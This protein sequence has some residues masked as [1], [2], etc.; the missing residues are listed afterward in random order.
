MCGISGIVNFDG[1][2]V[3]RSILLRMTDALAHRGPD[4]SGLWIKR[5]VGFGHRRLAIRDLSD[6]GRQPMHDASESV[7]VTYNGEIYNDATIRSAIAKVAPVAFHSTCDAEVIAPAYAAWQT[8]AFSMMEGMFAI[9]LWDA[10]RQ[11]V[12]LAR[13]PS[14]IKPLYYSW[15]G[16]SFRFASEIKGLLADPVHHRNLSAVNLHRYLAQGYPGPTHTLVE[17]IHAVPPGSFLVASSTGIRVERYWKPTRSGEIDDIDTALI[18]FDR[19]W[20]QV[21]EDMLIS[22]VPV[23]LLLSGGIDSSL[24]ASTL[25]DRNIPAFT[26][27]FQQ[28]VFDETDVARGIAGHFGLQSHP[29]DVDSFAEVEQRFR[30]VVHGYDGNYADSS[31]LAFHAVCEGARAHV[32]VVLTGDG[33]DEF[34]GGYDTY[35]ASRVARYL[36]AIIPRRL[37]EEVSLA[38]FWLDRKGEMKVSVSE[39]VA[40]LAAGIAHANGFEHAQWRRYTYPPTAHALYSADMRA[41]VD[42]IDPLGEYASESDGFSGSTVDRCLLA[43]QTYY[44]P[45]DL[46]VKSD[47]MSMAHSI[48]VR[49]PFLDRRMMEFAGTLHSNLLTPLFGPDK[50]ILRMALGRTGVNEQVARA[51]KRGF[52]VPVAYHL[53]NGLRPLGERLLD[54]NADVLGA[55]LRPEVVSSLWRAHQNRTA[56]HGYVLWALLTLAVWR[57]SNGIC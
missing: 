24:I 25:R 9:G 7:V 50:R 15:N 49:V 21:V 44:L 8:G 36:G 16:Q 26:A 32:P 35:R 38:L 27:R 1:A 23:G 57:E 31:A 12:V 22:D 20:R 45:G 37:A 56:N 43:D 14:G 54:D 52:N 19:V 42:S 4:G 30:K 11:W 39:K 6:A 47:S 2:A 34:F 13:D 29:V 40:R 3:D 46:L 48:E 5:N 18:E 53:R 55:F 41:A 10:E 33:A 28:E 51:K 17:G